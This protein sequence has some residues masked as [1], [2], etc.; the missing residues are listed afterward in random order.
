MGL[1]LLHHLIV[2]FG[3]AQRSAPCAHLSP[4]PFVCQRGQNLIDERDPHQALLRE[5]S[6]GAADGQPTGIRFLMALRRARPRNDDR[7]N[8]QCQNLSQRRTTGPADDQLGRPHQRSHPIRVLE[9]Q[10]CRTVESEK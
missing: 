6:T 3:H 7:G 1:N 8:A 4:P 9:D 2:C 5:P 10:R